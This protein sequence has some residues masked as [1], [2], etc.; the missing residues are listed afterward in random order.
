MRAPGPT[1]NPSWTPHPR[2]FRAGVRSERRRSEE[3]LNL[4]SCGWFGPERR[5]RG[6][7]PQVPACPFSR[8][9]ASRASASRRGIMGAMRVL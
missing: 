5:P 1:R 2:L 9:A 8:A 4:A 3:S 6:L 7:T